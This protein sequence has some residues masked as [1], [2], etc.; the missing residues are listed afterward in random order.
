M[1]VFSPI[2]SVPIP[3]PR[4][5]VTPSVSHA[6]PSD[7]A[8]N[9][10]PDG[11]LELS[12]GGKLTVE[13]VCA[14]ISKETTDVIMHVTSQDFSFNG[15]VGK[16]LIKAGGDGIVQE[17]KTLGQ[18]ALFSTQYTGAGNLSANQIAHVI[19]P[20]QPSYQD[21][22]KCLE[23]FFDDISKKNI[24]NISFSSI[25]AG[26]MGY[27][28]SQSADLIL[29]NLSKIAQLKN[30]S[31]TLAR[32]VIFEKAK[33]SKF[34]DA[35][36]AYVNTGG[37]SSPSS[38]QPSIVLP[39]FSFGASRASRARKSGRVKTAVKDGGISIKIYSDN[40]GNIE[41]AWGELKRNMSINI[42]EQV[43]KDDVVKKFKGE[44]ETA[45]IIKLESIH[46]VKIK[47]DKRK[48]NITIK[49]HIADISIVQEEIR[50]ILKDIVE[51]EPKG[52]LLTL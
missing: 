20:G 17:C 19:G 6:G 21:L 46:D 2:Q 8:M 28:E 42:K 39:K 27:S 49:G 38:P 1:L 35:A 18:P 48:G 10:K 45:K 36:K 13:I 12:F 47:I 50:K 5:K 32:I 44:V 3:L 15:G 52:G 31:L 16:A 37:A 22:K 40:R 4:M 9:D 29:D 30:P 34:K 23:N 43:M 24:A 26:A 51:N 11:S 7:V 33:F 14:D 25:G 41:K